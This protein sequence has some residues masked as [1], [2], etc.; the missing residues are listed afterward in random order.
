MIKI[1]ARGDGCPLHVVKGKKA[2]ADLH[3]PG[4]V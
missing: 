4:E 2:I 3:V 1:D